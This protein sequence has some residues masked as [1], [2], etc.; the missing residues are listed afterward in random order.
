[1]AMMVPDGITTT[2][3]PSHNTPSHLKT[4]IS[5]AIVRLHRRGASAHLT[6][7][8]GKLKPEDI[9]QVLNGFPEQQAKEFFACIAPLS[10]AA[11]VLETLSDTHKRFILAKISLDQAVAVL[12]CL[13]EESRRLH[14]CSLDE[15]TAQSL[16]EA[17]IQ[18]NQPKESVQTVAYAE[19]TAG[20][21]METNILALP[22]SMTAANAIRV[23]Q[24][25]SAHDSIFYLYVTDELQRLTGVCSLRRLILSE[26]D[27][28]LKEFTNSRLIKVHVDTPQ[29]Q[30]ASLVSRYRLLAMPVVD[31]FGM[32]IGQITIDNLVDIIQEEHTSSIMKMVG[33]GS[34]N[35][36]VL[37]QSIFQIFGTRV[38]WLITAFVAYLIVSAILDGF[39]HTLATVV[40][41]AFF[42]PIVIGMSG[43]AGSQTGAVVV[44][45]LALGTIHDAHFFK[46][47]YKELAVNFIQGGFY[48]LCLAVASYAL[49][50]NH[51]LSLTLGISMMLSITCSGAIA[52]SLP[53]FFKRLGADPAV[54]AG[55]LALAFIDM[56]GSINYLTVAFFIF[57]L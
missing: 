19:G 14:M 46:L 16:R 48:G 9:A 57:K 55:P 29:G 32:L 27:K 7:L 8:L 30:V 24:E 51:L 21:L 40:Q 35:T 17:L 38:P 53:F 2:N 41:L 3:T 22:D 42:F 31:E 28:T 6:Q 37:T 18:A 12:N 1:M 25:M 56:V 33:I 39:E 15:A 26:P 44:R 4:N 20:S 50:Q 23:V 36:N 34:N 49:F 10:H 13:S 54:A 47:L 11:L 45:G 5:E 52:M 43:N